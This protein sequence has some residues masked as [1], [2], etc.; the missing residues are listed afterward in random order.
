MYKANTIFLLNLKA[1]L[2]KRDSSSRTARSSHP[3]GKRARSFPPQTSSKTSRLPPLLANS[4]SPRA[5]EKLCRLGFCQVLKQVKLPNW[6]RYECQWDRG[7]C[8]NPS[9][10]QDREDSYD[11]TLSVRV[12][13]DDV[14]SALGP[15]NCLWVN[16][17]QRHTTPKP[18]RSHVL[19]Y[20]PLTQPF[21]KLSS[22]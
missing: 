17:T 4:S 5:A 16:C 12:G 6:D 22:Q 10:A 11:H 13:V 14:D 18:L 8:S 19:V 1:N 15:H 20:V 21:P 3:S 2:L 7:Q 9:S